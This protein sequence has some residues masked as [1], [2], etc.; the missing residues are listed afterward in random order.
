MMLKEVTWQKSDKDGEKFNTNLV[1]LIFSHLHMLG[2]II[3]KPLKGQI[4][5]QHTIFAV[6]N[7]DSN[8]VSAGCAIN[9]PAI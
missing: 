1:I 6:E 3:N 9:W 5:Q 4:K 7:R 2:I 8:Y